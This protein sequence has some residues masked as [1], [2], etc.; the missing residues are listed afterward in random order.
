[1]RILRQQ[2]F[3]IRSRNIIPRIVPR[4]KFQAQKVSVSFFAFPAFLSFVLPASVTGCFSVRKSGPAS[5]PASPA[6]Q[7]HVT[8]SGPPREQDHHH[9]PHAHHPHPMPKPP[10]VVPQHSVTH[11]T[12]P[13]HHAQPAPHHSTTSH[14]SPG[15]VLISQ[16]PLESHHSHGHNHIGESL[17]CSTNI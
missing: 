11:H 15:V 6:T 1:M 14:H 8:S 5:G 16:K 2:L 17:I 12:T 3:Q 10:A 13:S 4:F 7:T 9:P